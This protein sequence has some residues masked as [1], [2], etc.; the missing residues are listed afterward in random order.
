MFSSLKA[1]LRDWQILT[2][3]ALVPQFKMTRQGQSSFCGVEFPLLEMEH[4]NKCSWILL[5]AGELSH[6][7]TFQEHVAMAQQ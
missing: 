2:N 5:Q 6:Q 1:V 7:D 3:T 4:L